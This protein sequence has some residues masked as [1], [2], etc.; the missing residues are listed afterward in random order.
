MK[1]YTIDLVT[2][3][4]Y[5]KMGCHPERSCSPDR[6]CNPDVGCNPI[7][8][9]NNKIGNGTVM[10]VNSYMMFSEDCSPEDAS[11]I[12]DHCS[13]DDTTCLPDSDDCYPDSVCG[14]ASGACTPEN[15]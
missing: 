2:N 11:C 14:P 7:D 4:H 12:P 8:D 15:Y 13:P 6:F 1:T 5:I 10:T 9:D 3:P